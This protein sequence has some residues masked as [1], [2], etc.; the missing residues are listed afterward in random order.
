MLRNPVLQRLSPEPVR[1]N[2][3]SVCIP[4]TSSVMCLHRTI[5]AGIFLL[6]PPDIS[7]ETAFTSRGVK[8]PDQETENAGRETTFAS[9]GVKM[10][11][12]ETENASRETAFTSRGVK[13]PDPD[14]D[15]A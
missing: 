14:H 4:P 12:Q 10:P 15:S 8:M 3:N 11:D 6:D 2:R 9:R 5:G 1:Q 7:R 13:M